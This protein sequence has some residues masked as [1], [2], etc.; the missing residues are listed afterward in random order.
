MAFSHEKLRVY[1]K[2]LHFV[3]WATDILD[4]L[5][6]IG[7]VKNQ[8]ERAS[9]SIPLNIAEGNGKTSKRDRAR[10]L[11]TAHRSAVECAACLDIIA[12]KTKR[13]STASDISEG[14]AQLETI[15]NM[16]IGMLAKLESR[17]DVGEEG[18]AYGL[19]DGEKD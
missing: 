16:L 2:S 8:L 14:K 1:Q 17:Y 13:D 9:T 6:P 5:P 7:S 10:F 19:E 4:Q 15:V 11:Q 18:A 3:I 12:I